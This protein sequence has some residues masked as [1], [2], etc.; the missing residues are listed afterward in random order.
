MLFSKI[1]IVFHLFQQYPGL[2]LKAGKARFF[3]VRRTALARWRQISHLGDAW[4]FS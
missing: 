4:P 1:E 3:V 2:G